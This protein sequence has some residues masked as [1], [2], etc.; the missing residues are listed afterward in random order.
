VWCPSGLLLVS[1]S[2]LW[3]AAVQHSRFAG[4]PPS[5]GGRHPSSWQHIALQGGGSETGPARAAGERSA[6]SCR[7]QSVASSAAWRNI[8]RLHHLAATDL[9]PDSRA[10]L[11]TSQKK[12]AALLPSWWGVLSW[13][14]TP[15][16]ASTRCTACQVNSATSGVLLE[17]DDVMRMVC[18]A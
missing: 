3:S 8:L 1:S 7:L 9:R 18:I 14:R 5:A 4:I 2:L 10:S 12:S 13:W 17:F 15:A 16:C 6:A 11:R